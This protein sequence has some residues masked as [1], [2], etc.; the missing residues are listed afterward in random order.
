M[1]MHQ[2][3]DLS[4]FKKVASDGKTSTLQHSKGHEVKIAHKGLSP[5][6]LEHLK[7]M[8][9]HLA[10]TGDVQGTDELPVITDI[11]EEAAPAPAAPAAAPE[12]EP[13]EQADTK[14]QPLSISVSPGNYTKAPQQPVPLEVTGTAHDDMT[15]HMKLSADAA[16]GL[17]HPND[18]KKLYG[19]H[20]T[21]GRIGTMFGLMLSGA[22]SGLS[23]QPNLLMEMMNKELDRDLEAQKANKEGG[24]NF[25]SVASQMGLQKAQAGEH[26]MRTQNERI[27]GMGDAAATGSMLESFG[28]PDSG[29]VLTNYMNETHDI[30]SHARAKSAA[31]VTLPSVLSSM[32]PN[33]PRAQEYIQKVVAPAAQQE[34]A[35]TLDNGHA[36]AQEKMKSAQEQEDRTF[37]NPVDV[38]KLNRA[39]YSGG[40]MERRGFEPNLGSISPS[41]RNALDEETGVIKKS[42]STVRAYDEGVRQLFALGHGGQTPG[43]SEMGAGVAGL[44][45]A[46]GSG[47]LLAAGAGALGHQAGKMGEKFFENDRN[48]ILD[49]LRE[50]LAS[51]KNMSDTAKEALINSMVP[52]YWDK[53]EKY[54][55]IYNLGMQHLKDLENQETKK[56]DRYN[57]EIPGLKS[58][59]PV[60]TYRKK[61]K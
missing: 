9:L 49:N 24:R 16:A 42:R 12:E 14:E 5:K 48:R 3:F 21:L 46:I 30:L 1:A 28:V 45:G 58:D 43:L 25:L 60:M 27:K 55:S 26:L 6:M 18:I 22:G 7:G 51:N 61:K 47:G 52:N 37:N 10:E 31:L 36:Q 53:P 35:K 41:E 15:D 38:H 13:L 39:I 4:R 17:I 2:G 23:H 56:L 54:E 44:A 34:A 40:N 59:F 11:P 33:N 29:N 20:D 57:R 8:P 19:K 50:R 32:A